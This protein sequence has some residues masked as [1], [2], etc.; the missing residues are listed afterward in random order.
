MQERNREINSQLVIWKVYGRDIIRDGP[1]RQDSLHR[2]DE[3][4][5]N[6]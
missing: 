6:A 1:L 5:Q 2:E 4:E 3:K